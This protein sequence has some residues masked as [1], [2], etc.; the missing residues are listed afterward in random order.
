IR[1]RDFHDARNRNTQHFGQPPRNK[2]N[3]HRLVPLSTMRNGGQIRTVCF[4]N[5]AREIQCPDH[6]RLKTIAKC[7]YA[8]DTNVKP[9]AHNAGCLLLCSAEAME[10]TAKC[11]ILHL[12]HH[13]YGL[14]QTLTAVD[15]NGKVIFFCPRDL[16]LK[17]F[18]LLCPERLVPVQVGTDLS[19]CYERPA[20]EPFLEMI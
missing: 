16:N 12:L 17:R 8:T 7:R 5:H 9:Q 1:R 14:R 2:W 11:A 6:R 18:L 13:I 20:F 10:Y 15:D 19:Y 3:I 4:Q